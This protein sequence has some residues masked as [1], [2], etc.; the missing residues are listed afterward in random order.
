MSGCDDD[1]ADLS[2][3]GDSSSTTDAGSADA[4]DVVDAGDAHDAGDPAD[5]SMD[6]A[7]DRDAGDE[8]E[9]DAGK[10]DAGGSVDAGSGVGDDAGD[11]VDAGADA[12]DGGETC[13]DDA[14]PAPSGRW[15]TGDLHVHT[16]Q[17]PDVNV[18]G[19]SLE[20]VLDKAFVDYELDWLTLAN[21]LRLSTRMPNNEFY[22]N[23]SMPFSQALRLYERPAVETFMDMGKYA[24]KV[25][26]SAVEWDMPTHEHVN[27]GIVGD[28]RDPSEVVKA[29]E[30]FEYRFT[31][32]E[33]HHFAASDVMFW[34]EKNFVN[35]HEKALEAIAWLKANF[36][37]NS[38][39]TINHPSRL[40][41]RYVARDFR[42]FNDLAPD[43][44][45][46]IEGMVGNQ[47]ESRR[48]GFED[49]KGAYTYGGVDKVVARVGGVW[50]ALLGEGRR[51]WNVGNSDFHFRITPRFSSGYYPGEYA[52][53]YVWVNGDGMPAIL[54]GLRSGNMFTVYGDLISAL[55]FT[56]TGACQRAYMGGVLK[57]KSGS[58]V[59]VT[60]RFK[61]DR[62]NNY[63]T[64]IG[65]GNDSG[66]IPTV[67]H[68]DLIAGDVTEKALP[69]T[70]EYERSENPSAKVIARFEVGDWTVDSEG[71]NVVTFDVVATKDQYFRLRGTNLGT[72]EPGQTA[73]G[74]PLADQPTENA[75]DQ[76]RFNAI[77]ERNYADLWFYSNPIFVD[78]E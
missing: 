19:L 63:E 42:E 4:G 1:P 65:S 23:G 17:S 60:I 49:D 45:F 68:I 48:G 62:K 21:H 67:D 6:A 69:N 26:F 29:L 7:T 39:A 75:N 34:G 51:M 58:T 47:M 74:E 37:T 20:H 66:F 55:D 12:G 16:V 78:V 38:Y 27:V 70:P 3:A 44:V 71:Y 76:E 35:T 50:D 54:E 24:G 14:F 15:T 25:I 9:D 2:D 61:S 56:L 40:G 32:R 41:V 8:G 10:G 43:I 33:A 72:D 73:A 59:R 28:Q 31:D 36:P 18:D 46:I 5:A 22:P 30:E 77:N 53:N 13:G 11:P 64:P 57:A 52:K